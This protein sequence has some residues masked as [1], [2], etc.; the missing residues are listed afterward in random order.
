MAKTLDVSVKIVSQ[1][2]TCAGG[3]KIG[4]EWIIKDDKTPGGIC[5][6]AFC[7]I[8]PEVRVLSF[9]GIF[10]WAKDDPDAHR[11]ACPDARN[12]VIFELRR[13]PNQA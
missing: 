2:G 6:G 10:P 11:V 1:E 5:S 13:L 12:P 3:H 8:F 9:G 7:A 4:D